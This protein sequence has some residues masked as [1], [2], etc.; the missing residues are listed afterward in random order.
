MLIV[1]PAMPHPPS[2]HICRAGRADKVFNRGTE[3]GRADRLGNVFIPAAR[4]RSSSSFIAKRGHCDDRN[5]VSLRP[6]E[7]ANRACRWEAVH[8]V[9][10]NVHEDEVERSSLRGSLQRPDSVA[11]D[12]DT[13]TSSLQQPLRID[14][15]SLLVQDTTDPWRGLLENTRLGWAPLGYLSGGLRFDRR[16]LYAVEVKPLPQLGNGWQCYSLS[17]LGGRAS[18]ESDAGLGTSFHADFAV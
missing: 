8:F 3:L 17:H 9:H 5:R 6:R 2:R 12:A 18:F 4:Q 11:G 13:V 16:G 15:K 10:H 7:P 1:P 14:I